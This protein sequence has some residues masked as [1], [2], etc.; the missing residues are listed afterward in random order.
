[1]E[2]EPLPEEKICEFLDLSRSSWYML[3]LTDGKSFPFE[4]S[5]YRKDVF[6]AR[7]GYLESATYRQQ[8]VYVPLSRIAGL[9]T[10]LFEQ[11]K[12][13]TPAKKNEGGYVNESATEILFD[14]LLENAYA[15]DFLVEHHTVL[16]SLSIPNSRMEFTDMTFPCETRLYTDWKYMKRV[17]NDKT[18]GIK[19]GFPCITLTGGS[20]ESLDSSSKEYAQKRTKSLDDSCSEKKVVV[21][22][23]VTFFDEKKN[24][25]DLHP[26]EETGLRME[27]V[28]WVPAAI[29]SQRPNSADDLG[30]MSW[31]LIYF[32]DDEFEIPMQLWDR[33]SQPIHVFSE[34]VR[35]K[36][37]CYMG[38]QPC[39][40]KAR[41]AVGVP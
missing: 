38:T 19:I 40:L 25:D 5:P 3:T 6:S 1:M 15:M 39:Y 24:G 36:V 18:V 21:N 20:K 13:E 16:Y 9:D 35:V 14:C 12:V 26:K 11:K 10:L 29:S 32:R 34:V 7:P 2:F 28:N 41:S 33:I 22:G 17:S 8:V 23:F 27:G 31:R 37:E 4:V 30:K